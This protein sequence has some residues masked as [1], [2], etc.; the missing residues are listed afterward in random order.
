[1]ATAKKTGNYRSK[2]TGE[3]RSYAT[4]QAVSSGSSNKSSGGGSSGGGSSSSGSKKSSIS[5]DGKSY[6][7]SKQN[8]TLTAPEGK[9]YYID[10]NKVVRL[11]DSGGSSGS[12]SFI[13]QDE[14]AAAASKKSQ[15]AYKT[16]S[17]Y[18]SL[19]ADQ[20]SLIDTSYGVL[21]VGDDADYEA[22]TKAITAAAALADPYEKSLLAMARAEIDSN[23][24]KVAGD[25]KTSSD[26]IK[27][28]QAS[29][30]ETV[31]ANKEF[32]TLEQQSDLA[33][34]AQQYGKDLISIANDAA[35]KGL[36]FAT[37]E[38]S[39]IGAEARRSTEYANVVQTTNR[40][41][42]FKTKSLEMQAAQG[43]REAQLKLQ[44]IQTNKQFNIQKIGQEYEKMMG[45]S[46][47]PDLAGYTKV[48]GL[49]GSIAE[50]K[51]K[52]FADLVKSF[53]GLNQGA[54]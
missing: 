43:D 2:A 25:Y 29:L 32:L 44:D 15:A 1:M 4:G 28:A 12:G 40:A 42:N 18:T 47:M 17:F 27:N 34:T 20:K 19:T 31:A 22:L 8:K 5:S 26:I 39:R 50:D 6:Y 49:T 38:Q 53:Y 30:I 48:G 21:D 33:V 9:V 23:I 54:V 36:T 24:A 16:T 7:S 3:I 35:D 37:G 13:E 52:K 51:Q 45:S 14:D 11:R 41:F 10:S 46:A